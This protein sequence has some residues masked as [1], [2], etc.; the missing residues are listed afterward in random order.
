MTT[1]LETICLRGHVEFVNVR[2]EEAGLHCYRRFKDGTFCDSP[3]VNSFRLLDENE[4]EAPLD[5]VAPGVLERLKPA[6]EIG[7]AFAAGDQGDRHLDPWALCLPTPLSTWA[8]LL[9]ILLSIASFFATIYF[10]IKGQWLL[11]LLV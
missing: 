5:S 8:G 3:I 7:S 9:V 1:K 2:L 11:A 10:A 6:P 4:R